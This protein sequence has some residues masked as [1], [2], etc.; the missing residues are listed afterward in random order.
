MTETATTGGLKK[1]V[2]PKGYK[3]KETKEH[4][5]QVKGIRD[6]Y[7]EHYRIKRRNKIIKIGAVVLVI[8]I[9]LYFLLK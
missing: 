6:A 7:E 4:R 8:L 1:F 3:I 5:E 2:Y 9:A